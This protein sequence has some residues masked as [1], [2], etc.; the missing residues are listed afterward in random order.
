MGSGNAPENRR[1]L[2]H[3]E[4]LAAA[5]RLKLLME[6]LENGALFVEGKKDAKALTGLGFA[7]VYTISGNLRSS[8]EKAAK[9]GV[10]RAVVLTDRDER[11]EELAGEA[12]NELER[13]G[14]TC[15]TE[16]R[17][18]IAALLH[19]RYFED[20]ERKYEKFMMKISER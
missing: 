12:R 15:D 14:I 13:Y 11:G 3:E 1:P 17:K 10:T 19:L 7:E 5:K 6:A 2:T 18:K 8:C 4:K 16:L 20:M 9:D